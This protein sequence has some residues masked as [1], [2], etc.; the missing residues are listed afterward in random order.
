MPSTMAKMTEQKPTIRLMRVPYMMADSTSRP[1]SS[2]PSRIATSRTPSS[3]TGGLKLS[4]SERLARSIGSCGAIQGASSGAED[5]D[6]QRSPPTS[7]ATGER[8]KL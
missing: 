3:G 5:Q 4:S 7:M 1:W 8:R 6:Q 2:V